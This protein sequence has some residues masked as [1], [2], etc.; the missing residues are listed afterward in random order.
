M[1]TYDIVLDLLTNLPETRN[2]DRLLIWKVWDRQGLISNGFLNCFD[3]Y[4]K[5]ISP[6]SIRRV[7]QKLQETRYDLKPTSARVSTLRRKKATM[8]GT[9]IY[10]ENVE[11]GRFI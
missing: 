10:R 1:K 2:N 7:R 6:E 11:Q 4:S 9:F 8:R 5:A 3:F